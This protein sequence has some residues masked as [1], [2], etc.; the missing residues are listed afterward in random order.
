MSKRAQ[1]GIDINAEVDRRGQA[2]METDGSVV[3]V[4]EAMRGC[5]QAV[6]WI[7]D[8]KDNWYP[9]PKWHCHL[10]AAR[11]ASQDLFDVLD[12]GGAR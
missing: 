12:H 7:M 3:A 2:I 8:R 1:N 6:F 5:P 11:N 10:R 4:I 9:V